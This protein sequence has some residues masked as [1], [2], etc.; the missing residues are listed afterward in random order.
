M[1]NQL[2]TYNLFY[3]K[4]HA[5]I[6]KQFI[7]INQLLSGKSQKTYTYCGHIVSLYTTVYMQVVWE[8]QGNI[9]RYRSANFIMCQITKVNMILKLKLYFKQTTLDSNF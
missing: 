8:L 6:R 4:S 7:F 2:L 1:Q 5:F 9:T 3:N